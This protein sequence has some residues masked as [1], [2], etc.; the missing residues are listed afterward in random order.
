MANPKTG[1]YQCPRCLGQD[2]YESEEVIGAFG[3]T[4]NTPGPVDP[5]LIN[6]VTG[7]VVRCR[8]CGEKVKWFDS[9]ETTT[10]KAERDAALT[11]YICF[12]FSFVFF[13]LGFWVLGQDLDGTNGLIWGSFIGSGVLL[14]LGLAN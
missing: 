5:T 9:Q 8:N 6:P 7:N 14:L 4:L 1:F 2:V 11:K 13:I 10:Y 3:L 12:G